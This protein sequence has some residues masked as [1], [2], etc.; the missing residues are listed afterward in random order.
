MKT[1]LD[2]EPVALIADA[3]QLQQV[4]VNLVLNARDALPGGGELTVTTRRSGPWVAIEVADTGP[5]VAREMVAR[6]F[7]PFASTK[8]TGL[9]LG[10]VISKRIVEDHGGTIGAVNQPNGG[11]CFY[12]RL[13]I[14]APRDI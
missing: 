13:P 1:Y 2:A 4:F 5:G 12:V 6:L 8:D 11:A 9:G 14:G 3:G 10:L 7:E